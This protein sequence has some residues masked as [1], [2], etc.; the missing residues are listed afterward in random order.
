MPAPEPE[1]AYQGDAAALIEMIA[2]PAMHDQAYVRLAMPRPASAD[3]FTPPDST[4]AAAS[5]LGG[6]ALPT[7]RFETSLRDDGPARESF[8]SRLFVSLVQ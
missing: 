4:A 5:S 1:P 3:L 6:A 7:D 8:F 2:T